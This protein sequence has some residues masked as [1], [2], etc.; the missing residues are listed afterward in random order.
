MEDPCGDLVEIL[1]ELDLSCMYRLAVVAEQ[2]IVKLSVLV[3]KVGESPS[4]FSKKKVE[5]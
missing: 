3:S 2:R 1:N 4:F 5:K